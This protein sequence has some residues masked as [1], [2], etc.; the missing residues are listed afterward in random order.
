MNLKVR[1][2]SKSGAEIPLLQVIRSRQNRVR[3]CVPP[4][5]YPEF[6]E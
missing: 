1:N 2:C 6:Q 4:I 5:P 3:F